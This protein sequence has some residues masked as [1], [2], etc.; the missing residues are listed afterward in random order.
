MTKRRQHDRVCAGA[1]RILAAIETM[2][3]PEGKSALTMAIIAV[4]ATTSGTAEERRGQIRTLCNIL[5]ENLFGED[6]PGIEL[7]AEPRTLQ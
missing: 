4:I 6:E 1:D 7:P 3:E 5:N 2:S